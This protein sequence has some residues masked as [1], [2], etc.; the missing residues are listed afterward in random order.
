MKVQSS[1]VSVLLNMKG[2]RKLFSHFLDFLSWLC[3]L[4]ASVF[5]GYFVKDIWNDFQSSKT[6]DRIY[7]ESRQEYEHPTISLCFE[8]DIKTTKLQEYNISL[9]EF[10]LAREGKKDLNHSV[11]PLLND[12]RYKFGRDFKV[13][14]WMYF[15][16]N[17]V[18]F[19]VINS[20]EKIPENIT[21]KEFVTYNYG[22]C[23][24]LQLNERIKTN[25]RRA[26]ILKLKMI[27]D[28][29]NPPKLKVFFTSRYNFYGANTLQWNDGKRLSLVID[30]K[31]IMTHYV[32]LRLTL[33]KHLKEVS[34]CS[35]DVGFYKCMSTRL[36]VRI[37]FIKSNFNVLDD[38]F[39]ECWSLWNHTNKSHACLSNIPL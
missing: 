36:V 6:N 28:S 3:F 32:N 19:K 4:L 18:N 12:V 16:G 37:T 14:R 33:R 1:V 30:P 26:N 24:V 35:S 34:N 39:S 20:P 23:T 2:N 7:S 38:Y 9:N 25:V 8:P 21:V 10:R 17:K 29:E 5:L 15:D 11:L 31:Q 22:T 27:N 13:N